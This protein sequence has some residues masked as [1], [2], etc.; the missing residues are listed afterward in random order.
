MERNVEISL[1]AVTRTIPIWAE[2]WDQYRR[3]RN[4]NCI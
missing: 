1:N 3:G 4:R 2:K